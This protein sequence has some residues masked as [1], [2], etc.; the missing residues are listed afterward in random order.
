M[1][2]IIAYLKKAI[3]SCKEFGEDLDESSWVYEEGVLISAN[4]AQ[5]IVDALSEQCT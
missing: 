4:D 3:E 1:K 5:K 2:E